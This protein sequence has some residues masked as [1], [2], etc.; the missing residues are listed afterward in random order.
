[1]T[2]TLVVTGD[3]GEAAGRIDRVVHGRL[4]IMGAVEPQH[5]EILAVLDEV[6]VAQ[7][8]TGGQVRDQR[9]RLG[10]EVR[11]D[12]LPLFGLEVEGDRAFALVQAGPVDARAVIADR[13][14]VGVDVAA[15]RVDADDVGTQLRQGHRPQRCCDE[16]GDLND[17]ESGQW[18]G[19]CLRHRCSS[20]FC[21]RHGCRDRGLAIR[22]DGFEFMGVRSG[23]ATD[24]VDLLVRE[25]G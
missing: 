3:D 14:P 23:A 17:L 8:S 10:D 16:G 19:S 13:P 5:D 11:G 2:G 25:Q 7:P 15:D 24:E 20:A 22:S 9:A 4:P 6:L 1:M 12:L 18:C 21:G